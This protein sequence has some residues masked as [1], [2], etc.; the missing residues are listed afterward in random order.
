MKAI[1]YLILGL[2]LGGSLGFAA[3]MNLGKGKPL[4][5]DPL[6]EYE[7]GARIKD[8]GSAL[9]RKSGEAFEDIAKALKSSLK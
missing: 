4:L 3:G 2:M 5:S 7:I 9:L 6:P 8:S 1:K